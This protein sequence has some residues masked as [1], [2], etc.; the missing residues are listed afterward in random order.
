MSWWRRLENIGYNSVNEILST[1]L[2]GR[3]V[4]SIVRVLASTHIQPGCG[5]R[6]IDLPAVSRLAFFLQALMEACMV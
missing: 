6:L 4:C 2:E 5:P 1:N 3:L